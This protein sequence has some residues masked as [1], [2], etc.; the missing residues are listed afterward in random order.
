VRIEGRFPAATLD[1]LKAMGHTL[2]VVPGFGGI[3]NMQGILV[4]PKHGTLT[5]GADPRISGYA[6]GY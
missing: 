2:T 5:A 3:G 1:A 4:H 6:I